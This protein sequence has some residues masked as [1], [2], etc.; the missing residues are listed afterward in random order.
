MRGQRSRSA[1]DD[2]L[3]AQLIGNQAQY[4]LSVVLIFAL[5]A[6]YILQYEHLSKILL[7]LFVIIS[8]RNNNLKPLEY[9]DRVDIAS[10]DVIST[11][12]F[13][14]VLMRDLSTEEGRLDEAARGAAEKLCL[15]SICM[16]ALRR[17]FHSIAYKAVAAERPLG[18]VSLEMICRT[19]AAAIGGG[20]S[21]ATTL[22]QSEVETDIRHLSANRP[23][24][25]A[26][27]R[28]ATMG[29]RV[30]ATTDTY[31]SAK[32]IHRIL[33]K[34]V[35][36]HPILHVYSSSDI[37][38]T[39]H[40]G[41]L[42]AEV[43]RREGVLPTRILHLGDDAKADVEQARAAGCQAVHLPREIAWRHIGKAAVQISTFMSR[44]G[45]R[46]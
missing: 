40:S 33:A 28:L 3:A 24:I 15:D 5:V 45:H 23:L 46:A 39:K 41:A 9:I 29:K 16:S 36:E 2:P 22:Q 19:V 10:Y 6:A 8:R 14:T 37:G 7:K 35:G 20:V 18:D 17:S 12:L 27:M 32:E 42:F 11:D 44:R 30:V 38:L 13:D 4:L 31:Y 26:Y 43:A 34:V 21:V 25:A 1:W